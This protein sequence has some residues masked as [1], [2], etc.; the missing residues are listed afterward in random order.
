MYKI[1]CVE[2]DDSII[3]LYKY[4]LNTGEFSVECF[5]NYSDFSRALNETLPSLIIL[6][7]MLPDMDG[8]E[9]IKILKSR[10]A[11]AEI[12]II[13][14]SA[15][16]DEI[17]K[18]K[19][20]NLGAD[21]YIPKPFSVL[22]LIARIKAN[23]RRTNNTSITAGAISL[24]LEKHIVTVDGAEMEFAKK[25]FNILKI[26]MQNAGKV[27]TREKLFES[28]WGSDFMGE[29]R[30]LDMHIKFLRQKLGADR[31]VTVRGVGFKLVI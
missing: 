22:E 21:D 16:G 26:L 8:F 3:E 14:V 1:W 30:T 27:V 28:V 9:I 2:D 18:V 17:N 23:L 24:D 4:A 11:T 10:E 13:F 7:I 5:T 29:T 20:L 6:D 12:P 19:G 31:I 25:E 15:K